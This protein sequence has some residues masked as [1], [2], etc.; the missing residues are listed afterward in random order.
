[1][2]AAESVCSE[3]ASERTLDVRGSIAAIEAAMH[4]RLWIG[5]GDLRVYYPS[6][7]FHYLEIGSVV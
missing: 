5:V 3:R 4:G 1:M 7:Y 6:P 2:M